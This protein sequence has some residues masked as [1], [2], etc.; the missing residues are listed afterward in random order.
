MVMG[1]EMSRMPTMRGR[2]MEMP[3]HPM[4]AGRDTMRMIRME[5]DTMS[6]QHARRDSMPGIQMHHMPHDSVPGMRM[7]GDSMSTARNKS[8]ASRSKARS[9]KAKSQRKTA[10]PK[11]KA[12]AHPSGHPGHMPGMQMP[13]DS[14]KNVKP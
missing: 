9:Q 3:G 5:H 4:R 8:A 11:A 13:K 12:P 14:I 2:E 1:M 6:A 10:E 7:T